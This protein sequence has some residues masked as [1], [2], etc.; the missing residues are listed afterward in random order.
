M[1]HIPFLPATLTLR[2]KNR[3]QVVVPLVKKNIQ[4]KRNVQSQKTLVVL[5]I[6]Q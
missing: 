2:L 3:I 5:S 6:T 1:D 4:L